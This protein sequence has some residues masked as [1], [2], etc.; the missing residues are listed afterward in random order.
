[1]GSLLVELAARRQKMLL[2]W[3]GEPEWTAVVHA[4]STQNKA[5]VSDQPTCLSTEK[6]EFPRGI[7]NAQ[8]F[9]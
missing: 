7:R 4:P 9:G 1:M 8:G 6:L 3:G 2:L 5:S